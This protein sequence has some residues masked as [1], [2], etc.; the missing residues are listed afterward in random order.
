MRFFCAALLSANIWVFEIWITKVWAADSVSST[1]AEAEALALKKKRTA[2][3]QVLNSAFDSS[4][5]LPHGRARL[6]ESLV[7]IS[8]V[9][10]TDKGQKLYESALSEVFENPE[11]ALTQ[12]RAALPLEDN[13]LLIL[14]TIAQ[15]EI[16]RQD[17]DVALRTLH[18]ART[19]FPY[20]ATSAILELRALVCQK[21]FTTFRDKLKVLPPLLKG[22]ESFVQYLEAQDLMQQKMWKRATDIL[23]KVSEEEPRFPDVYYLLARAGH[24]LDRDVDAWAQKYISLC[25]SL[26]PRERKRF[27][28]EPR[29]CANAKEVEDDLA[30]KS[31]L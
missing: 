30:K 16:A 26:T 31:E 7:N 19:I 12:L 18:S 22:Q 27:A 4:S 2:A 21:N 14:D 8:K 20:S 29:L 11:V 6:N 1:I 3:V 13:N 25:K 9:F 28:F 10:F 24:E 15:I 23:L 17:C 5:I